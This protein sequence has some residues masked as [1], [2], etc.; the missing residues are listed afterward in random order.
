[1]ETATIPIAAPT[2]VYV[3]QDCT[4]IHNGSKFSSGGAVVTPDHVI[5]YPDKHGNLTDWHG[6]K[7]GTCRSVASWRVESFLGTHMHQIEATVNGIIYTGRGFG[8]G[9]IYKGKRKAKQPK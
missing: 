2:P 3:E 4:V 7:I 9:M 1:M 5:A 6:N 8:A